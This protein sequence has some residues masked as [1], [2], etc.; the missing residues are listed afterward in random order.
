[1][2]TVHVFARA[3]INTDEIIPARHLTTDVESELAKYA[4]EDYDK[5]FVRRVKPGDIIVAGADFGCGSS[6]E[7]AVWALRGAG[8]AAVIAPNFA[9]IFYR[10]AI[11][12]GFLALECE[13]VVETF[14]D[15]DPAELDLTGGTITN[16]RTGQTLTFVPVP[17]FALDVQKAGGW[18]EYMREQDQ[19]QPQQEEQHA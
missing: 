17:Q 10:N 11:N 14:M 1:M 12:N 4:M 3:H 2:P 6:R 9:R 7:H 5:N 13:D 15:G 19:K 18:L 16:A 8:V